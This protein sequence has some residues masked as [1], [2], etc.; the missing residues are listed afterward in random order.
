MLQ[1]GPDAAALKAASS[2]LASAMKDEVTP[3]GR[4]GRPPGKMKEYTYAGN[5]AKFVV[6]SGSASDGEW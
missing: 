2:L 5:F 6:K 4:V 1:Q 3:R